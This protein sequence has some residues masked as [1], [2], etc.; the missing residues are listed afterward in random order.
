MERKDL[1]AK[2]AAIFRE[3]GKALNDYAAH[4][5]KVLASKVRLVLI[6][7]MVL[8]IQVLVVGNP[9]NTNALIAMS[10]APSIPRENFT[11][12]TRLDHNRA[13]NQI[14]RKVGVNPSHVHNTIIWG[15]RACL[16][17]LFVCFLFCLRPH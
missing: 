9:A 3:Q 11:A 6:F 16:V 13:K 5:V 2:N 12:L 14:A 10:C 1:L 17:C 8:V 15:T 7:N 4:H